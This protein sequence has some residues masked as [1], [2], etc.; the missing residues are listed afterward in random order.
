MTFG[1][2]LGTLSFVT[3]ARGTGVVAEMGGDR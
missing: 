1:K 3:Y 2:R